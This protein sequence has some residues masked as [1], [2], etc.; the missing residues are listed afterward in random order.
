VTT[1]A[2]L[3]L[4]ALLSGFRGAPAVEPAAERLAEVL[5]AMKAAG[6]SLRT[7]S[8]RFRQTKHDHILDEDSV[9]TGKLYYRVPG[10]IRWEY[11]PPDQKVL[12]VGQDKIQVY[13]PAAR[14]V[15]E[16]R[17]GRMKGAEGELLI[18]LGPGNA[19]IGKRYHVRLLKE[20]DERVVLELA[21]RGEQ[22]LFTAIELTLEPGRW[23][24]A[25]T[26]FREPNRDTI[27]LVFSET[28]LNRA[29]PPGIFE[30]KLPPGV[31]VVREG[32]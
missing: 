5:A 19:E 27:E 16:L 4:I 25:R 15:Q 10:R 31:E 21:P 9:T 6:A 11:D 30:L 13:N 7:L 17:K 26:I 20:E 3:M 8:A 23:I 24:P 12:L 18:G 29:L 22:S 2:A 1:E 28:E 32:S 14:Q